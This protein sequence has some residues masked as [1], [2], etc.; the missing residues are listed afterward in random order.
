MFLSAV[1]GFADSKIFPVPEV[2]RTNTDFWVRIYTEV[3]L[4]EGLLHDSEYPHIVYEKVKHGGRKGKALS[5]H[6][7]QRRKIYTEAI[8][9]VR[10]SFENTWGPVEKQVAS[11]FKL[12]P[13]GALAG[14]HNR[15]RH[16]TGQK[17]RFKQGLERSA[18]YLDTISA[19]LKQYGVPDEL[20][21]LPHVESSFDAEAYSKVGAAGLWQF[22]RSTGRSYMKIDYMFDE[23]RDAIIS[24]YAAAKFLR[25]NYNMLKEWPLAI[26]AYNHGPNGIRRAVASVGSSDIGVILQKHESATFKF[27]SKNFYSCFVAVL[28]IM[29]EPEKYFKNI[30][31]K[32][33][34]QA[35]SIKLPFSIRA[36]AICK[37]LGITEQQFKQLNPSLRPIVFTQKKPIPA[38]Y[39]VNIPVTI[40]S[41][42]ALASLNRTPAPQRPTPKESEQDG[43]YTVVQGDNLHNIARRLG[44]SMHELAAA[45]NI[46]NSS[47]IY[48]GQVL[49]IP[50]AITKD[51]VSIAL[52]SAETE[53]PLPPVME[54]A[55]MPP[56][57]PEETFPASGNIKDTAEKAVANGKKDTGQSVPQTAEDTG[58]AAVKVDLNRIAKY[59][60]TPKDTVKTAAKTT[61]PTPAVKDTVNTAAQTQ[62]AVKDTVKAIWQ[63]VPVERAAIMN[64]VTDTI[65]AAVAFSEA[66][67]EP[68]TNPNQ[69]PLAVTHFDAAVYD[70]GMTVAPGA[71]SVR[72]KI[73][74]DETI[75]HFAEWMNVSSAEIRRLNNLTPASALQL[76]RNI[77]VPIGPRSDLKKFEISRLEYHMAI[78][79]DFF[80]QYNIIDFE[81]KKVKSGESLWRICKDAHIP[82]WLLKKFNRGAD[83][84]ALR[85]GTALWI[86]KVTAKDN[87]DVPQQPFE[88][89]IMDQQEE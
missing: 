84:F 30:Q 18:M 48:V 24:T 42:D 26:T 45:N 1:T 15:V 70:L 50:S 5:D 67:A 52:A 8:A 54:T 32:P 73:S 34:F 25:A 22:M 59:T 89:E 4:E 51:T 31:Y 82:M 68:K 35:T 66:V 77:S 12:A 87:H 36:D 3:S 10:D 46:T 43:Y 62:P 74:V 75:S 83:V 78:E 44:I 6:I 19:I 53:T 58:K 40:S 28:R 64:T 33:K 23:R 29:E 41:K 71:M 37:S 69:K 16:Q 9:N 86:P 7:D 20:K 38:G 60:Q 11:A 79:E 65:N 61:P 85:P 39:S 81:S 49:L 56:A 17:E 57:E 88:P 47:R 80:S 13:E 14:A 63:F 2:I 27:A 21:Y 72:V 55:A 76:G